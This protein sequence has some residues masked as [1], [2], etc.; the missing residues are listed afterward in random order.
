MLAGNP[1]PAVR[2]TPCRASFGI[3][4]SAP[5]VQTNTSL[6]PSAYARMEPAHAVRMRKGDPQN[7]ALKCDVL[8]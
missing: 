8:G 2:V 7:S 3:H 6:H 4:L 1:A 5:G